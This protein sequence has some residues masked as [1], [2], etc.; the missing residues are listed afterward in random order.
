M[1]TLLTL[2]IDSPGNLPAADIGFSKVSGLALVEG[3]AVLLFYF[4][5]AWKKIQYFFTSFGAYY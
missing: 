5:P 3:S 2:L 4:E 1:T